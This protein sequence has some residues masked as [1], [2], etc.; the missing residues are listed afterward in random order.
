V[1]FQH[2]PEMDDQVNARVAERDRARPKAQL[3][4]AGSPGVRLKA[5]LSS[6]ETS[7]N[8]ARGRAPRERRE[9]C[10]S[11]SG[12][13]EPL[14]LLFPTPRTIGGTSSWG[15]QLW[16][17]QPARLKLSAKQNPGA[18]QK[19]RNLTIESILQFPHAH[20]VSRVELSKL[21]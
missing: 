3:G 7:T 13:A 19:S 2:L 12:Y 10:S 20:T 4:G 15:G 18:F 14:G 5:D 21:S 1:N 6:R 11:R 16:R 8:E 9:S 17:G